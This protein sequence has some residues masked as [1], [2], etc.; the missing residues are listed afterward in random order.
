MHRCFLS[1]YAVVFI[2][3]IVV[4]LQ[5]RQKEISE[6]YLTRE[7]QEPMYGYDSLVS[8]RRAK[9]S[10]HL[11]QRTYLY[12]YKDSLTV[13]SFPPHILPVAFVRIKFRKGLK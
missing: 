4:V 1:A 11:S 5:G 12:G 13:E 7:L 3:H 2:V 10:S 8:D 6:T 9:N